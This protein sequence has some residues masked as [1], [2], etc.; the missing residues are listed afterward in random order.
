[1][2]LEKKGCPVSGTP[3]LICSTQHPTPAP[4]WIGTATFTSTQKRSARRPPSSCMTHFHPEPDSHL[5]H[6]PN[7]F[8]AWLL[9]F[10]SNIP[11]LLSAKSYLLPPSAFYACGQ[12]V[13]RL[14]RPANKLGS[15][16]SSHA[17]VVVRGGFF[18]S[19]GPY[20]GVRS[21]QPTDR[22]QPLSI[23]TSPSANIVT[24]ITQRSPKGCGR[25]SSVTDVSRSPAWRR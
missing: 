13:P 20:F 24:I 9:V 1:M 10:R 11:P 16:P 17:T 15:S 25:E 7:T 6:I 3:S 5:P 18:E 12:I 22:H 14:H 8:S 21:P 23:L 2:G 19:A 4:S